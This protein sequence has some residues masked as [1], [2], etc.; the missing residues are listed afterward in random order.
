[1]KRARMLRAAIGGALTSTLGLALLAP[2][3]G[4][5][6]AVKHPLTYKFTI[7]ELAWTGSSTAIAATNTHGDLYY[8]AEASGSTMWHAQVVAKARAGVS[9][10]KPAIAWN[11]STVYIAA[12]NKAGALVYFVRSGGAWRS[13]V[14]SPAGPGRL[15]WQTPAITSLP[16]GGLLMTDGNGARLE[17]WLLPSG[18]T[19]WDEL[20]V[21]DG[22]YGASSVTTSYDGASGYVGVV[23][24]ATGGTV[25]L[26]QEY[27]NALTWRKDTV[28]APGSQGSFGSAAVTANGGGIVVAAPA[29]SGAV[30][31]WYPTLAI[32]GTAW[33][34]QTVTTAADPA[35]HPAISSFERLDRGR[36][37]IDVIAATGRG[38][39]LDFWY[40]VG[41]GTW[42][43][44][45][46]AKAG[47]QAAY[48]SPTISVNGSAVIVTAV[49]TKSGNVMFW[50]QNYAASASQWHTQLVAKG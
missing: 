27:L 46:I 47:Q 7:S 21:S 31:S 30:D 26:W 20:L 25:Y 41:T 2:A 24:A 36:H 32:G 5:G 13:Y 45:T 11:G 18:A 12:V 14:Q 29:S 9:Y 3:T 39:Q 33:T 16:G 23:T 50:Y 40:Q 15:T 43:A 8:F 28:A 37:T 48:G 34:K 17:S 10:S 1:M 4:A 35:S 22:R 38:G 6:A 49:N 19:Q 44:E 42:F